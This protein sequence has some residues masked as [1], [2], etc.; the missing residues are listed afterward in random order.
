M[1]LNKTL[2]QNFSG[3]VL[4]SYVWWVLQ[5]AQKREYRTLYFLAR[6]GY[7]LREIAQKFCQRFCLPIE[8]RYLYCSRSSLRMPSYHLIGQETYDLLLLGG[9]HVTMCSLLQRAGLNEKERHQVYVD[10]G[11]DGADEQQLLNR[12]QLDSIRLSLKKSK[13]YWD[14]VQEK[15]ILAY[16]DTIGYMRQEGL[17]AQDRAVLVDSGWTGSMQRSLRQLLQS[18]DFDG[19]LTGFYFGMYARPKSPEDGT[20]LPWYFNGN[21]NTTDKIL[22]C[23]NLFE[24]LLMAPH[25]MTVGYTKQNGLFVPTLLPGPDKNETERICAQIERI[26][27]YTDNRLS[28]IVFDDFDDKTIKGDIRWRIHRY[29]AHPTREEAAFYGGFLFC[30]DTTEAYHFKLADAGQIKALKGYSIAA[31]VWRRLTH[32]EQTVTELFWPYGTM[33]FLPCRKQLWYRWNIYLWE[34]IR[35][36]LF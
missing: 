25:G 13:C 4:F 11:L 3:P 27:N 8:C 30:D 24:C 29:M 17:L 16:K 5:Q 9:Y 20:Y 33:A 22:F 21:G 23:N 10:C 7:L 1:D 2:C 31:R 18:S 34:W 32:A 36:E 15:S 12:A 26:L 28:Q 19:E 35:Y 6:D 14:L